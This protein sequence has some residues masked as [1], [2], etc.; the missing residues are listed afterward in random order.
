[1]KY[2]VPMYYQYASINK[3]KWKFWKFFIEMSK[4]V[5]W[6]ILQEFGTRSSGRMTN[7]TTHAWIQGGPFLMR[8]DNPVWI[9]GMESNP[10]WFYCSLIEKKIK[11]PLPENP[12]DKSRVFLT[13]HFLNT[14][15]PTGRNFLPWI[16]KIFIPTL[17]LCLALFGIPR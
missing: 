10:I 16:K 12:S 17:F 15:Y 11:Q 5:Y 9:R 4:V 14:P 13:G 1:M 8:F 2:C 6:N 7:S 3:E